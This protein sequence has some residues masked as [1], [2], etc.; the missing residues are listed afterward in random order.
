[1]TV[2][3]TRRDRRPDPSRGVS[4]GR[5]PWI[6]RVLGVLGGTIALTLLSWLRLPEV[7]RGTAW[8]EDAAV[9][10]QEAISLGAARS[11]IEPYAGY[12]HVIPRMLSGLAY[13]L[14]PID[15]YGYMMSLLSC[16]AVAAIAVSVFF[17]SRPVFRQL[18][19]RLM[20]AMIPVFLPIG[21]MEVLGN[22][23][24][25][26]WYLL[27]LAPWLLLYK[28]AHWYSKALL[29]AAALATA[30]SE[31]IT[32]LFVPLALWTII[33][34]KNHWA[35]SGLILGVGLQI[36][37][38]AS[39]PRDEAAAGE[40][41]EPLSVFY[42]F[43]LQAIGSLWETDQRTVASSIVNFGGFALIVPVI[44]VVGLL[45]YIMFFGRLK[46][47]L[48]AAYAFGAAA[49]CWTAAIV[50]NAQPVFNY[51]AFTLED[52]RGQFTFIRY[53]A[54]PSMFL[55]TLVPLAC[56]VAAERSGLR[57]WRPGYSAP[58]VLLTILLINYFPS[59]TT[60]QAGP[61][62]GMQVKAARSACSADAAL[63]R[64]TV[65]AAPTD[66]GIDIPCGILLKH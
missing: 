9:F 58:A 54:A 19:L 26:H 21:P 7:S 51:A 36:L 55:L 14:A 35:S 46:W 59:T 16:A 12:L 53:A 65:H 20:L 2:W 56:A 43:V 27:W 57:S 10:L 38:T 49:A 32:G 1:M 62:W 41:V 50:V 13:K 47:K 11:I 31:I 23:A 66:W 60:R 61:E 37:V 63:G 17:L 30:T 64:A 18:P 4:P 8:A 44:I 25:L 15:A 42:G 39:K 29:F 45:A 24:N 22:A 28:P 34:R 3:G 5:H 52:W 6:F 48:M 33:W 40:A